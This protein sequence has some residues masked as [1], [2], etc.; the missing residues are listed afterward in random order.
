M[1][2][3]GCMYVELLQGADCLPLAPVVMTIVLYRVK[4]AVRQAL[5]WD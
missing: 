3:G 1:S 2:D 4:P 5:G